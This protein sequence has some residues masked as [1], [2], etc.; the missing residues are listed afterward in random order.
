M[1][2]QRQFIAFR[3]EIEHSIHL[4]SF[5]EDYETSE[6]MLHSDTFYSAIIKTWN[7]IGI[8]HPL[9]SDEH[10]APIPEL[11]FSLSS[12][13][14]FF[15]SSENS[16][17]VY[18]F[19]VPAGGFSLRNEKLRDEIKKVQWIDL[20]QFRSVL[21]SGYL[22]TEKQEHIRGEFYTACT[23][24]DDGFI[25]AK[26]HPRVYVPRMGEIDDNGIPIKDAVVFYIERF[27]FRE[28]C[29][30]FCLA[31]FDDKEIEDNVMA[32][33]EYLQY[34]GIGTDRN[35]GHGQF[36][37]HR[38]PFDGF[39]ELPTSNFSIS[40]SLFCPNNKDELATILEDKQVRYSLLKRGGW[41]TSEPDLTVRKNSV[42][43]FKE[44]SIF[45]TCSSVAGKIVDL[46]PS[47]LGQGHPI[48]RV[49]RSIFLPINRT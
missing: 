6:S 39:D 30:F 22:K 43:M 5:R 32:A 15:K 40:I 25:R 42:Y 41:I 28:H 34:Q 18:F 38:A 13:F 48:W 16:L 27:F 17:P 33:L 21:E 11:G 37:L 31:E 45:K 10:I 3:F 23:D 7:D 4:G 46:R 49:G 44:G 2:M 36:T 26:L 24:F 14:P 9:V 29:G 1:N 8:K 20:D 47:V 19:P 35:V 12:L